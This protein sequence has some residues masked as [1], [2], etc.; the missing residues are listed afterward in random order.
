M[1]TRDMKKSVAKFFCVTR[2]INLCLYAKKLV[3]KFYL[4]KNES[5]VAF[6]NMTKAGGTQI[7]YKKSWL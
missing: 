4:G 1:K 2:S 7:N 5:F 6:W 3:N